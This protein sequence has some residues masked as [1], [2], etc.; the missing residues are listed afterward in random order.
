MAR[1]SSKLRYTG[2]DSNSNSTPKLK[3]FHVS[4][5]G[6]ITRDLGFEIVWAHNREDALEQY[7]NEHTTRAVLSVRP[8]YEPTK[9]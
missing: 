7:K 8:L 3:A 4:W 6:I 1:N 5:R 2:V 9:V